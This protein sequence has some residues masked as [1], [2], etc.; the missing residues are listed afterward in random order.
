MSELVTGEKFELTVT[1]QYD[2][3][4][5]SDTII[6]AIEGGIGYWSVCTEYVWDCEPHEVHAKVQIEDELR[7]EKDE[8]EYL[9]DCS[10]IKRGLEKL[11]SGNVQVGSQ[12]MGYI[13]QSLGDGDAGMIDAIA[14]DCIVQAGLFS[15]VRYG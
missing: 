14:A 5:L 1:Q 7:D 15:E 13:M 2:M 11:L 12:I 6:T 8:D 10:V 3:Q 4:I 9:I